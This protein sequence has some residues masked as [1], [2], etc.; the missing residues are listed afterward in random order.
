MS[1]YLC[2]FDEDDEE[3]EGVEVGGYA[4]FDTFRAA[5]TKHVENGQ[6]GSI[7]PTMCLHS[8]CD[9]EWSF[10]ESEELLKELLAIGK[11]F[12]LQPPIDIGPGWKR[13]VLFGEKLEMS[14]LYDCFFDVD[15]DPLITR[16]ILLAKKSVELELPIMFQ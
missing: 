6:I 13:E 7:C 3:V 12:Q 16:L 9:G 2:I 8:D 4:D 14:S 10:A 15:G 5:I 1:L 11:V